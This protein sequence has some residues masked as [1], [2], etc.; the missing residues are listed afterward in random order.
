MQEDIDDQGGLLFLDL[1]F[2]DSSIR[3]QRCQGR[4]L[5]DCLADPHMTVCEKGMFVYAKYCSSSHCLKK[6]VNSMKARFRK[7]SCVFGL[8][9]TRSM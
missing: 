3:N 2:G 9:L 7:W 5:R 8:R 4:R 6:A 1:S